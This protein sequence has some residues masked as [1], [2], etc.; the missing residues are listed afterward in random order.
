MFEGKKDIEKTLIALAQ[1]LSEIGSRKIEIVVCGGA[2][3]NVVGYIKRPTKDIDM[4]ALIDKNKNG[5]T[6][7]CKAAPMDPQLSEAVE[8]VKKY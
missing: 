4:V 7:L 2:A 6:V 3:L 1:Q 5:V 8:Q